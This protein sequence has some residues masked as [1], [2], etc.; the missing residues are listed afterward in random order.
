MEGEHLFR[1]YVEKVKI[2][3]TEEID[4]LKENTGISNLVG[5]VTIFSK[6]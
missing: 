4:Q 3:Q 2:L 5:V 6:I 1:F